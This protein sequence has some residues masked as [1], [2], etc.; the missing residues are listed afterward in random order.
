MNNLSSYNK[1]LINRVSLTFWLDDEAIQAWYESAT[2]SSRG[3][4]QRY[5]DLAITTVLVIK[6]VFRLTL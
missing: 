2:P 4:T 6:R 3:R 5:Y 1:A